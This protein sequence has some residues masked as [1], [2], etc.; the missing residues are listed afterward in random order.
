MQVVFGIR[1][2]PWTEDSRLARSPG[3]RFCFEKRS[4]LAQILEEQDEALWSKAG[5]VDMLNKLRKGVVF[6]T[7]IGLE[8][9]PEVLVK[10]VASHHAFVACVFLA[11]Q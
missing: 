1:L 10:D 8:K 9:G 6:L 2:C 4:H 3:R 11:G 5:E 7:R